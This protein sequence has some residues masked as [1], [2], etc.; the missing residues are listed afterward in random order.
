[1]EKTTVIQIRVTPSEKKLI[2]HGAKINGLSV[3][4]YVRL[5]LLNANLRALLPEPKASKKR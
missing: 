1:M 3:S 5:A 2:Q 4:A